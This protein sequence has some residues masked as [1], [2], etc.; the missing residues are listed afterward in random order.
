MNVR[1]QLVIIT[2]FISIPIFAQSSYTMWNSYS[3]STSDN[4]NALFHNPAGLGI[5]RG[6]QSGV[7]FQSDSLGGFDNPSFYCAYRSNGFGLDLSYGQNDKYEFGFGFASEVAKNLNFGFKWNKHSDYSAGLL[8]RPVNWV[9]S[10]YTIW[11]D[12]NYKQTRQEVGLAFRPLALLNNASL[13]RLNLT[14]GAEAFTEESDWN[15]RKL[16]HFVSL[17]PFG[18]LEL[19]AIFK[20]EDTNEFLLNLS[21]N[22]GKGGF[23]FSGG[24]STKSRSIGYYSY[25]QHQHSDVKKTLTPKPKYIRMDLEGI[26]IEER[27]YEP[28]FNLN[29]EFNIFGGSDQKGTQLRTWID[30]I[31]S[32]TQDENIKG[33]IIDLGSVR[34][35][36]A[37][38]GEMRDALTRFKNAGKKIIVHSKHSVSNMNYYLV[39]MADEIYLHEMNG[40]DLKGLNMEVT[41]IRSLLDSLYIE[42]EV[43]RISP[44]KT[45]GDMFLNKEMSEEMHVNYSKM[46]DDYYELFASGIAENKLISIDSVNTLIDNGP[47]TNAQ[48]AIDAGLI[49]DIKYPDEFETYIE[50]IEEN[51]NIVKWSD[52][53]RSDEY[54]FDWVPEENP[55]IAIVYAVGGIVSGES[56]PSISGSTRMGDETITKAI[57]SARENEDVK[58]VVLRIDSGGGSA[59]ASDM[60]WKEVQNTTVSDTANIKPFIASMSDVAASGG[61]YIACQADTIV[62]DPATLTGSIGVI[63]LNLNFSKLLNK[64][65]INFGQIKRG[66]HADFQ[67]A[68]RLVTED[69]REI[70]MSEIKNIYNIFKQRV[71]D[72]RENFNNLDSLDAIALGRVWSGNEAKQN[73]LIDEI[74][75]IHDAITLAKSA[76]GISEDQEIDIVE[77][78]R[79]DLGIFSNVKINANTDIN[80]FLPEQLFNKLDVLNIIPIILDDEIQLL[81]PYSISVK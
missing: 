17:T 56:N 20:N 42:P 58:A 1:I 55:K 45:A 13:Q 64:I 72:G 36:F 69:E 2:I 23:S 47:Y 41:F 48:Y 22:F 54:V 65:G 50:S 11:T 49:T 4:L 35:G 62:A 7:F 30:E 24:E 60:M 57:K 44:Y 9:S 31:D 53:D 3:V 61:Y 37:K 5:D 25:S 81:V 27:P 8:F 28:P 26:F 21:V 40:V 73:G 67:S 18:G 77:Y 34:A 38:R 14:V 79:H 63:G 52:I 15:S 12:H 29:I 32:F 6:K 78:P 71:I 76:A 16:S 39:S 75:G 80:T 10:G 68:T 46:L 66:E 74:G 70:I 51:Y 43:F 19:S 33:L 59:L